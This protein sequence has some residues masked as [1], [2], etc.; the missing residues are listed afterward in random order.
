MRGAAAQA[1]RSRRGSASVDVAVNAA[2]V[3]A[4]KP[5]GAMVVVLDNPSGSG[6]A[7]LVPVKK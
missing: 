5:L 2:Q 4:Q 7:L 3:A 1:R 6:E